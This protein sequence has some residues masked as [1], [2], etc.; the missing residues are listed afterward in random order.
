M[1]VLSPSRFVQVPFLFGGDHAR[2][3]STDA[4]LLE[5]HPADS[6]AAERLWDAI[7]LARVGKTWQSVADLE[8]AAFRLYLPMARTLAHTPSRAAPTRIGSRPN[9]PPNSASRTPYWRGGSGRAVDSVGSPGPRSCGNSKPRDLSRTGCRSQQSTAR[10]VGGPYCRG[11]EIGV[12]LEPVGEDTRC[13]ANGRGG[14][15]AVEAGRVAFSQAMSSG[16]PADPW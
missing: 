16:E 1:M 13:R 9:R 8:D 4:P 6:A 5:H 3:T 14:R 10:H 11:V 15:G 7:Y 2:V 12:G